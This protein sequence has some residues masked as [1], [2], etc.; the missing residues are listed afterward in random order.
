MQAALSMAV[1]LDDAATYDQA[2]S[3]FLDRA[4]AFIYLKSDGSRPNLTPGMGSMT[5]SQIRNYWWNQTDHLEDGVAQE[6]CRDFTHTGYGLLSFAHV[7][8]TSRIQGTDLWPTDIGTRLRHAL[9]FH[10]KLEL[11]NPVPS[12]LCPT[13]PVVLGLGMSK[14]GISLMGLAFQIP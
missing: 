1:F 8:E 2:M 4:R 13:K 12:W 9:E 11:R 3:R 6:T 5:P 7:A 10:S 14:C